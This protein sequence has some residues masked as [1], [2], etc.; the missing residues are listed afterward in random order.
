MTA[1][2]KVENRAA[3]LRAKIASVRSAIVDVIAQMDHIRLQTIPAIEAEYTVRVGCW[4]TQLLESELACRRAKRKLALAQARANA[5]QE[6]G[7][8]ELEAMEVQLDSE[9]AE[10][11][12]KLAAALERQ[13]QTLSELAG[14]GYLSPV[15]ARRIKEV[16]RKLVKRLHPDL[17][18]GD[19]GQFAKLFQIA[20]RAYKAGSLDILEALELS[21][22]GLE[23]EDDLGSLGGDDL[24]LA[25]ELEQVELASVQEQL[26]KLEEHPIF[27]VKRRLADPSWLTKTV[28]ALK[29]KIAAFD[30]ARKGY[31]SRLAELVGR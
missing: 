15:D 25:L 14:S 20:V 8:S 11:R 26:A 5:G 12:D 21:T 17:H 4:E 31:E 7:A 2:N 22:R 18:P 6:L 29:E 1:E 27:E 16:Y 9:F 19:D 28:N 13:Q 23:K 24:E 10:W 30:K 3:E